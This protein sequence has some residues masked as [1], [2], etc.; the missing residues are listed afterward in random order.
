MN[1]IIKLKHIVILNNFKICAL[2]IVLKIF[3]V[4]V[5][6][7]PVFR[8]IKSLAIPDKIVKSQKPK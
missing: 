5:R 1:T 6:D 8:I 2:P 7:K 3:L 4:V